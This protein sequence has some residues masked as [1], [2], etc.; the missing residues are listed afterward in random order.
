M[1]VELA[2]WV[3]HAATMVAAMMTAANVGARV[4]GWGFVVF[5]ISSIAWSF[6]GKATG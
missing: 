5:T 2:E 1:S 4:T 3:A 6:I